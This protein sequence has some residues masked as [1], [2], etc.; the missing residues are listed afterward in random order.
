[1]VTWATG[2]TG[3]TG[4]AGATG[5]TVTTGATGVVKW[6]IVE[7]KETNEETVMMPMKMRYLTPM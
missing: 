6:D 7:G 1:M 3:V 2:V 4:A 5:A